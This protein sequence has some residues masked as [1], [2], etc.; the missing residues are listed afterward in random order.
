ML[1]LGFPDPLE[2]GQLVLWTRCLLLVSIR[3]LKNS[4][5]MCESPCWTIKEGQV[6]G[7]WAPSVLGIGY[8]APLCLCVAVSGFLCQGL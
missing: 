6:T 2:V 3:P 7:G 5:V 4:L 1:P 8:F